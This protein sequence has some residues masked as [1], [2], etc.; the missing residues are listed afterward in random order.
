MLAVVRWHHRVVDFGFSVVA[1][2]LMIDKA[3]NM[4]FRFLLLVSVAFNAMASEQENTPEWQ[5]SEPPG[6][7]RTIDIDTETSTWSFVDVSPDGKTIVFDMLGDIYAMPVG[8]GTASALTSGI[9]WNFQPAFSLNGK[10]I[11]FISDRDGYDNIWIMD[12]DGS[13]PRQ[14]TQENQHNLHNPAWSPDGQWLAARKGTVSRCSSTRYHD[15]Q[16]A[17]LGPSDE[18]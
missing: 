15:D 7:W 2:R 9:E 16:N 5:V 3:L 13:N 11:A 17:T 6:P 8:G 12:A 4:I 10:H 18:R 1:T 14:I